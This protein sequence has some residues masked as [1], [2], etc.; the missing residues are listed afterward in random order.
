MYT[1]RVDCT[2]YHQVVTLNNFVWK[3]Q[4][5]EES[6][7]RTL[8]INSLL[9]KYRMFSNIRIFYISVQKKRWILLCGKT[10][11]VYLNYHQDLKVYVTSIGILSCCKQMHR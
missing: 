1:R 8:K 10:R 4:L 11:T 5:S 2:T 7:I 6:V 9:H 3:Y